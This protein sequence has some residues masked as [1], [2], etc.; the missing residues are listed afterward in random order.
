MRLS[1]QLEL[2]EQQSSDSSRKA[3]NQNQMQKRAE[4]I[5]AA[6]I[7]ESSEKKGTAIQVIYK[8]TSERGR[9]DIR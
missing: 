2:L 7:V 8:V 9:S 3:I 1:E 6:L 5:E 4:E